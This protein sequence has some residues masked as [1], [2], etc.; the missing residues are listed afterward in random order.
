MYVRSKVW[1]AALWMDALF[2]SLRKMTYLCCFNEVEIWCY[3]RR[4]AILVGL[5]SKKEGSF[6]L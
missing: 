6:S 4:H 2:L 5:E 3:Y 1:F